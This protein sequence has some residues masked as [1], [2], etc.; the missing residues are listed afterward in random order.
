MKNGDKPISAL[1]GDL[2]RE[3]GDL[4]QQEVRLAKTEINE[5]ISEMNKGI[6][7]F[8]SGG[9]VV[10]AGLLALLQAVIFGLA[11]ILERYTDQ[12]VWLAPLIVGLIVA[13]IGLWLLQKGRHILTFRDWAPRRTTHSLNED[14]EML[15]G[16]FK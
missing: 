2:A 3:T 11:A 6:T 10:F 13:G 4:V 5:K 14:K 15:K 12:Y 8:F 9:I 7:S 1:L 16:Q